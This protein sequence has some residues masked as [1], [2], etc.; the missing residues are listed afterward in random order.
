MTEGKQQS[1][2][3][4]T[5]NKVLTIM[6]VVGFAIIA[7]VW[8]SSMGLTDY[9]GSID[10]NL[11]YELPE[12]YVEQ[13]DGDS[14]VDE[15]YFVRETDKTKEVIN[16]VYSVDQ[17]NYGDTDDFIVIDDLTKVKIEAYDWTHD[18]YNE[19]DC[20]VRHDWEVYHLSYQCQLLDRDKYYSSCSEIQ[21]EELLNFVK[22][23]DYHRP[24]GEDI[25]V[26][27]RIYNNLGTSGC[28]ILGLTL[29]IFI[30]FPIAMGI[31]GAFGKEKEEQDDT[32]ASSKNLHAAM[33]RERESK[34]EST[35]PAIN[36]VQGASTNNLARRDK[37]WSSVP[38]FFVKMITKKDKGN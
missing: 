28:I 31:S 23:F 16:L 21:Q 8:I 36:N 12:G 11:S 14:N 24:T 17:S 19:L 5:I 35:I 27:K 6:I 20:E 30:G 1:K 34:G 22:T 2:R 13:E 4:K 10:E 26:F 29:L 9:V 37:S 32:A 18:W 25:S 3:K 38:D 7:A 33:N 15:K